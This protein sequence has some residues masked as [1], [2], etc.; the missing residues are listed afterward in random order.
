MAHPDYKPLIGMKLKSFN[1][2]TWKLGLD[3]SSEDENSEVI[4]IRLQTIA[5]IS[6]DS[7]EIF[8]S[9]SHYGCEVLNPS[10]LPK[11]YNALEG[12]VKN[13]EPLSMNRACR[14]DFENLSLYAWSESK[15]PRALFN[16]VSIGKEGLEYRTLNKWEINDT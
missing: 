11:L 6:F 12:S 2:E 8:K 3:F 14:M 13:F 9:P 4:G 7:S 10:L 16:A 1:V 15:T 5:R